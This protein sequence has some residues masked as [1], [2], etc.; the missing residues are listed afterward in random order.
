MKQLQ[1]NLGEMLPVINIDNDSLEHT[2]KTQTR[3]AKTNKGVYIKLR[4][5][6]GRDGGVK[7]T[8]EQRK[9]LWMIQLIKD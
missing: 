2:P 1:E 8:A 4:S 5:S 9:G 7:T 6:S 3:K